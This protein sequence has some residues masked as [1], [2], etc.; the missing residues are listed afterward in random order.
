MILSDLP[1]P[2]AALLRAN[3]TMPRLRAGGKQNPIPE[4][5]QDMLF[6]ITVSRPSSLLVALRGQKFNRC[7]EQ[8]ARRTRKASIL[9]QF[10]PIGL[11]RN[12]ILLTYSAG[13]QP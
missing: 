2:A 8:P 12:S 6:G 9:I 10:K 5:V 1:T 3:G 7:C 11:T 4:R 13:L